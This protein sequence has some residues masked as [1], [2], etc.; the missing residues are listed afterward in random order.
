MEE[1][2]KVNWDIVAI[3][4]VILPL[5]WTVLIVFVIWGLRQWLQVG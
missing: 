4:F 1:M 5:F 3:F 2:R